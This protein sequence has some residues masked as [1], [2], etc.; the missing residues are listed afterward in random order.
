MRASGTSEPQLRTAIAADG[1]A[2]EYEVI[3][4]G[5]PV[6]M[7]H[8]A[9][10]GRG[11]WSRQRALA[12]RWRLIMPSAR[13]HEGSGG[14]LPPDYGIATTDVS[15][16]AAIVAAE[17]LQQFDLVGH[18]SGGATAFA[19]TRRF[20]SSIRRLVMIEPTLLALLPPDGLATMRREWGRLIEVARA[21]GPASGLASAMRWLGREAWAKLEPERR[22]KL[23][24]AMAPT[25]HITGPH[26]Q[27]LLDFAVTPDEVRTLRPAALL[28]YGGASFPFEDLIARHLCELRPDWRLL[29]IDGA[30]HNCFR[31]KA[32]LANEAIAAFLAD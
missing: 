12:E 31:E 16:V 5:N 7:L 19:F 2:M 8:G 22:T 6:V 21:E 29:T 4:S 10:A 25:A 30:S 17:G 1:A 20:P 14:T 3:G 27:A 23:L 13:A 28:I 26:L 18:S 11:A 24:E 32:D 15:D 9:F